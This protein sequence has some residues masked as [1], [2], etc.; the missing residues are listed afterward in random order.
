MRRW[1]SASSCAVS[2]Y[3]AVPLI[4]LKL[5]LGALLIVLVVNADVAQFCHD[6]KGTLFVKNEP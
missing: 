1:P 4:W 2:A 5:L 3:A 6:M